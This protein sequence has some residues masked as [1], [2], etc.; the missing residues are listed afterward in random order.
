MCTMFR[1]VT[2]VSRSEYCDPKLV[3]GFVLPDREIVQ[4]T[5]KE[6][7]YMR[8]VLRRVVK[9]RDISVVKA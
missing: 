9:Q 2:R 8:V 5:T 3:G 6:L 4:A 1:C 7:A